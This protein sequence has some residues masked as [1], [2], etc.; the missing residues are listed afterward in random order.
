MVLVTVVAVFCLLQSLDG[1]ISSLLIVFCPAAM[2]MFI[3]IDGY[4]CGS[5]FLHAYGSIY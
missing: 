3:V 2:V 4:S 1:A 5:V